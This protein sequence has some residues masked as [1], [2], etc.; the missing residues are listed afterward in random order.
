MAVTVAHPLAVVLKRRFEFLRYCQEHGP[1]PWRCQ[2]KVCLVEE[3]EREQN[4]GGHCEAR[5][6]ATDPSALIFANQIRHVQ[7]WLAEFVEVCPSCG[8]VA[9]RGAMSQ[10]RR[11][12]PP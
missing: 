10:H 7:C 12:C 4:L 8:K 5:I 3:W 11:A 9:A 2:A 6:V 1:G